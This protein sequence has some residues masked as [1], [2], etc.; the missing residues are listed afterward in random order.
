[1]RSFVHVYVHR[2]QAA[3]ESLNKS[4]FYRNISSAFFPEKNEPF[5][6][7]S[8]LRICCC[9]AVK[10]NYVLVEMKKKKCVN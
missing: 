8:L 6:L 10:K 3:L 9:S 2:F 5:F 4:E 1:M 7:V